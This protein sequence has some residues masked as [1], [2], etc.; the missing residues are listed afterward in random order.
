MP[1]LPSARGWVAL[2][3][4]ESGSLQEWLAWPSL[5]ALIDRG[6]AGL[7]STREPLRMEP[8]ARALRD[9]DVPFGDIS[10]ASG[11]RVTS[12]AEHSLA[13]TDLVVQKLLAD[14]RRPTIVVFSRDPRSLGAVA[15]AGPSL[16]R[17]LLRSATTRRN[18]LVALTDVAPTILRLAGVPVPDAMTGRV[19]TV[20]A[21]SDATQALRTFDGELTH[22]AEVRNPLVRGFVF[23]AIAVALVCAI[24]VALGRRA[25]L[26]LTGL[27]VVCAVPVAMLVE[28]LLPAAETTATSAAWVAALALVAGASAARALGV[29]RGVALVCGVTALV[30][31]ADLALGAP[32]A[33][34]SPI[35]YLLT[36]GARFYGIGN[37]LMGV[38]VGGLIVAVAVLFEQRPETRAAS[39]GGPFAFAVAVW[40]MASP[41]I[42]AKFGSVLTA[43]PAF[44][45]IAARAGGRRVTLRLVLALE[46]GAIALTALVYASDRLRPAAER[47]HIGGAATGAGATLARKIATAVRVAAFSY[48]MVALIVFVAAVAVV[49]RV[50]RDDVRRIRR[51]RPTLV[52][53]AV[54]AGIAIVSAVAFND[55]GTIAAA[56]IA[57][58][59]V[60]LLLHA[61]PSER[62]HVVD[63]GP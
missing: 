6:A 43:L 16:P 52:T 46:A 41:S 7:L 45:L 13:G 55:A 40:L 21:T 61:F 1:T 50:R 59:C 51:Q 44:A 30:V 49:A 2:V 42:G 56:L 20:V 19:M 27:V 29:T 4:V 32:L 10:V 3:S 39:I 37:E 35:S 54:A 31:L 34:R 60:A 18:G 23:V 15:I 25:R 53:V 9:A 14:S 5:A 62:D 8:L 36:E 48:W 57:L 38:V 17:G 28:P 11:R 12:E 24:A 33:S 47:S 63:L 22:A 58:P 26:A